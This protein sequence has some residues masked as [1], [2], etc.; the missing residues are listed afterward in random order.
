MNFQNPTL[1]PATASAQVRTLWRH[2]EQSQV[3]DRA[4][5][6]IAV[7]TALDKAEAAW[8]KSPIT[9]RMSR[10]QHNATK[11]RLARAIKTS[12][13]DKARAK[14]DEKLERAGLKVEYW[15]NLTEDEKRRIT[16]TLGADEESDEEVV[17]VQELP[18]AS[19]PQ[20]TQTP[21]FQPL[22]HS[23]ST[24]SRTT[25]LSSSSYAFVN[26]SEFNSEDEDFEF[27][28]TFSNPV[29]SSYAFDLEKPC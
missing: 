10:I 21:Y 7:Q 15:T 28:T 27:E 1:T 2:F 25:N 12:Y 11:V 29:V 4:Q 8:N 26:P 23:F 17:V 14:W 19:I 24:S 9:G 6:D 16:N 3:K 13:F 20:P 18:Q 5:L 22:A